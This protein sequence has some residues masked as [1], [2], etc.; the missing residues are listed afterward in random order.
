MRQ[1]V[2]NFEVEY[3][4]RPRILVVKMGQNGHNRGSRF[5][6][7]GFSDLGFN[8]NV[9]TLF[10]TPGDVANLAADYDRHGIGVK[11]RQTDIYLY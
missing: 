8:V 11:S 4:R 5:I 10:S 6:M 3:G 2:S 1:P 9:G 7:S